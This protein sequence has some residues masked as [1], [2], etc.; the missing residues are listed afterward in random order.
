MRGAWAARRRPVVV[1]A[2]LC[3]AVPLLVPAAGCAAP[4]VLAASSL[5]QAFPRIASGPT[6]SFAGSDLLAFQ[7]QRGARADVFASAN[8]EYPQKLRRHHLCGR[9]RTFATNRLVIIVPRRNPAH[10]DSI[11]DLARGRKK[12]IAVG[13]PSVP[14]GQYTRRLLRK[15]GLTRILRRNRVSSEPNVTGIVGKVALGSADAGF[16]YRTDYR[17]AKSRLRRVAL[18]QRGQPPVRYG[19]CAVRKRG[20]DPHGGQRFIRR[21]R[22]PKGRRVLRRA[23]FGLPRR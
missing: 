15:L 14:I 2:Y 11:R 20:S 3:A 13:Q 1:V 22:G 4:R 12:R 18:P 10:I 8:L 5:K 16:V 7:I 23:G 17:A 6:F 19:I 21:V 9:V